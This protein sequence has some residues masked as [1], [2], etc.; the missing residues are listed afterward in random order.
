[1]TLYLAEKSGVFDWKRLFSLKNP[2]RLPLG[3]TGFSSA[4]DRFF[5]ADSRNPQS[6]AAFICGYIWREYRSF[7]G[8]HLGTPVFI[9]IST[10]STVPILGNPVITEKRNRPYYP[11]VLLGH[12]FT[13]TALTLPSGSIAAWLH[14]LLA[15][16]LE[17][18]QLQCFSPMEAP[19]KAN[20]ENL[21]D[22]HR[23][24]GSLRALAAALYDLDDTRRNHAFWVEGAME[25]LNADELSFS[26]RWAMKRDLER[27]QI[28]SAARGAGELSDLYQKPRGDRY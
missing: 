2:L 26:K 22:Y 18:Q 13:E 6:A 20:G 24:F 10:D 7:Q 17:P 23:Q 16:N 14:V 8:A 9:L 25:I 5:L 21:R 28:E 4:D 3:W 15:E 11:D 19:M 1:M 12:D 27:L